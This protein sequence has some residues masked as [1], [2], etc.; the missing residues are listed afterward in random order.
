MYHGYSL[1]L[2]RWLL[3]LL[4]V[5]TAQTGLAAAHAV[6]PSDTDPAIDRNDSPHLAYTPVAAARNQLFV[7]FP[8]TGGVPTNQ[9][10]VLQQAANLGYHAI[11]L[12][13][14]NDLAI[15]GPVCG[16]TLDPACFENARLEIFDG[17][18]RHP[19]IDVNRSNSIENRLAALLT[20]LDSHHPDEGWGQYLGRRGRIMWPM[21][22]V[23]GHSQGAGHA[24]IIAKNKLVARAVMFA[25]LDWFGAEQRPADWIIRSG[26]TPSG[27]L[28]G[29][30]H[31]QDAPMWGPE[32]RELQTW[33]AYG[34]DGY[35]PLTNVDRVDPPYRGSHM[36][37]TNAAPA[38]NLDRCDNYHGAVVVDVYTP[39]TADGTPLYLPVW[40]YM[41]SN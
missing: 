7:F 33:Q 37:V 12:T 2:T 3:A 20:Y 41:L 17:T 39:K 26:V 32:R 28:Y 34:M 40:S 35:G 27:R 38:C 22:A 5:A 25:G 15:N 31:L 19:L 6:I 23:A 24:G 1:Q 16:G 18:D 4:L 14:V 13:Y 21:I 8:G 9:T 30:T 36:L 10:L 11:G 29:F